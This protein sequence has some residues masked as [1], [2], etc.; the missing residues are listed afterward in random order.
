MPEGKPIST[1]QLAKLLNIPTTHLF[2]KLQEKGLIERKNDT[3]SL[4]PKGEGLGGSYKESTKYGQYIVWPEDLNIEGA[5][6]N[7]EMLSAT[8]LGESFGM[9]ARRINQVLS[10]HGWIKKHL[11]G[12]L[13]TPQGQRVGGEQRE[14]N[15]S[16]IPYVL[17]PKGVLTNE[18]LKNT[19]REIRGDDVNPVLDSMPSA[20]KA[21]G[22]R[23]KLTPKLRTA[24]GH[25]V[26]SRAEM[27][28]D[29]WL[30]TAE[31]VHAYER[32]LPIEEEVYC[33]FYLPAG[34]V[35]IEFWGMES[36][37]KYVE[38]KKQ[39]KAIYEQYGFRLI[40]LHDKDIANLDDVL[41]KHLLKYE[42]TTY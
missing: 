2:G 26:R 10:E 25:F 22:F 39:K 36:D 15:K 19:L 38:R 3:W 30:Y 28:I 18:S 24:D 11:K 31:I 21:S 34:K 8:S 41:P 33:D 16:G 4:T 1:T 20:D 23:D 13:V 6:H 27:L 7:S 12:W 5:T 40:E 35:Y 32:R 14:S 29:N 42:I 37:A 9:P 17:W